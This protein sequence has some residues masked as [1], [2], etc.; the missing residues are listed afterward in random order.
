MI[1][2]QAKEYLPAVV[3]LERHATQLFKKTVPTDGWF[4]KRMPATGQSKKTSF[5][6]SVQCLMAATT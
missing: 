2:S 1:L 4:G 5:S 3:N 6:M